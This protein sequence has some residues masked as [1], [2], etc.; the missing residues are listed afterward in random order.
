M[1]Y[2][3]LRMFAG[4]VNSIAVAIA[5]ASVVVGGGRIASAQVAVHGFKTHGTDLDTPFALGARIRLQ[6]NPHGPL[7]PEQRV[8]SAAGTYIPAPPSARNRNFE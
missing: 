5:A 7:P 3:R 2:A 4:H 6:F 8:Q 1:R